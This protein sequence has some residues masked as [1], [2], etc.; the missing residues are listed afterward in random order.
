MSRIEQLVRFLSIA[1]LA[2]LYGFF[3]QHFKLFPYEQLNAALG[4]ATAPVRG[5]YANVATHYL[6]PA[7]YDRQGARILDK[8]AVQPG[9]TL[10]T[11]F[12]PDMDWKAGIKLLDINGRTVHQWK[13]DVNELWPGRPDTSMFAYIH[14]MY[15]FPNG[16]IL[17]NVEQTGLFMIDSCGAVKWHLDH[18]TH[19]S[20]ARDNDGNFWIPG[21]TKLTKGK[22]EDMEY[23][24][25][26][27]GLS[28]GPGN[29]LYE[30]RLLKV[31]PQGE[32]LADI[33]LLKVL[34]DNDLQRYIVKIS[35]RKTGDI[36]HLNDIDVLD[37]SMAAQYP[38]FAAGDLAVSL[39]HLHMVLVMDP[40][41]GVVKWY[42]TD[43]W[44]EQHDPDFTGDGWITVFDNNHDFGKQADRGAMLGGSRIVAVQPHTG[45]IK[46]VYPHNKAEQFYTEAAGK[47]QRLDNGNLLITE[48]KAGRVFEITDQGELVWEWINAPNEKGQVAEVYE[49][50]RYAISAEQVASWPCYAPQ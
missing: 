25:Q 26:F 50:S 20:V 28:P 22:P 35:K 46:I 33:S 39:R 4:Q 47:L 24:R 31:S 10:M 6:N 30:D 37:E 21:S 5:G 16:D 11:S 27:P 17:F 23:I 38:L 42:S 36:L 40:N 19:H 32:L 43:P 9:L 49:G 3:A 45:K 8:A 2:F 14:G 44:I 34:Y 7:A 48:A 29:P 18:V 15:L 41:T 13:T 12:W 1:S